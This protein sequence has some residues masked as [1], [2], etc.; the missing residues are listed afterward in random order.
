M[1]LLG[2]LAGVFIPFWV[3]IAMAVCIEKKGG[4]E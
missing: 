2:I 3:L 1:I 4:E